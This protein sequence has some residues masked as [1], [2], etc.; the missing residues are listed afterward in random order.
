VIEAVEA[1][2]AVGGV[3]IKADTV[4]NHLVGVAVERRATMAS[5]TVAHIRPM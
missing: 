5:P 3:P 4:G 1:G 2:G